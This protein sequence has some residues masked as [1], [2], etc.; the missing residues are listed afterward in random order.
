MHE[1]SLTTVT[2][3]LKAKVVS[4]FSNC[5]KNS[6]DL[7]QFTTSNSV[8]D[9]THVGPLLNYQEYIPVFTESDISSLITFTICT[10]HCIILHFLGVNRS[11][12]QNCTMY[13]RLKTNSYNYC[14]LQ[15][16]KIQSCHLMRSIT[17]LY[18]SGQSSRKIHC[19]QCCHTADHNTHRLSF[20]TAT[21]EVLT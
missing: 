12:V 10:I 6:N 14:M 19:V 2:C 18:Y 15:I 1:S 11:L 3:H 8:L 7:Q 9:N 17:N 4:Y 16:T 21:A 5:Q 20:N 13:I